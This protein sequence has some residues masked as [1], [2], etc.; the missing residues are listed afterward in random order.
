MPTRRRSSAEWRR[1]VAVSTPTAS[2]RLRPTARRAPPRAGPWGYDDRQPRMAEQPLGRTP[3]KETSVA[4]RDDDDL[5][6]ADFGGLVRCR[7]GDVA[8]DRMDDVA[9]RL[10]ALL[11]DLGQSTLD[12][13][14]G[15]LGSLEIEA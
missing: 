13:L 9:A 7:V 12:Q 15:F 8:D 4:L 1:V 2:R 6:G 14:A 5:V 3:V 11:P 10:D